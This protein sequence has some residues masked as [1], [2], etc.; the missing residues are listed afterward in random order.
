M[1]AGQ[2]L[3]IIGSI[4]GLGIWSRVAMATDACTPLFT[5]ASPY[6]EAGHCSFESARQSF[7]LQR[8]PHCAE[9]A[10]QG[11][12]EASMATL[13][14]IA[15]S[16]DR[17]V[18]CR[19]ERWLLSLYALCTLHPPNHL[20][21]LLTGISEVE[22]SPGRYQDNAVPIACLQAV[23]AESPQPSIQATL[24][25]YVITRSGDDLPI[26]VLEHVLLRISPRSA[27][28]LAPLLREANRRRMRGRDRFHKALCTWQEEPPPLVRTIC[29]ETTGEEEQRERE[30]QDEAFGKQMQQLR[31]REERRDRALRVGL[32]VMSVAL[33]GLQ[34]GISIAYRDQLGGKI[35]ATL[36][37]I[38]AGAFTI[39]DSLYIG[40]HACLFCTLNLAAAPFAGIPGGAIA[41]GTTYNPT[42]L[43][44]F[45]SVNAAFSLGSALA[46]TWTH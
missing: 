23:L 43:V 22:P 6:L 5:A 29:A 31:R 46:L 44:V 7:I 21:W 27:E 41:Y 39:I 18:P 30:R 16:R 19:T 14:A 33:A 38:S 20:D 24:W 2:R 9:E 36:G 26:D 28:P 40:R 4:L 37:G 13:H 12:A 15:T 3:L 32:S 45:S 10:S 25:D 8:P 1:R 35:A 34:V 11:K 42:A 17:S